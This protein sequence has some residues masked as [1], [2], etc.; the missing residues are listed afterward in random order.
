MTIEPEGP[1]F[2]TRVPRFITI[3]NASFDESDVA[4]SAIVLRGRV[5][6]SSF[7]FF[8][9]DKEYQRALEDR[10]DIFQALKAGHV[11]P[12]IDIGIRGQDYFCDGADVIIRSPCYIIDGWQRVGNAMRLL[13][14][15]PDTEIRIGALLHFGTN[16]AW[17]AARFTALNNNSKRVSPSLHLR[18]LREQN[19]S[20][21]TIYGLTNNER[22][23]PLIGRVC[24]EQSMRREHLLPAPQ[25]AKACLYL[26]RHVAPY[27]GVRVDAIAA[28]LETAARR[29]TLHR[30]RQNCLEFFQVIEQCFGITTIEYKRAATQLRGSF[31]L[32]LARMF[33]QHVNFWDAA[34]TQLH[35]DSAWRS[36]LSRFP[37]NDPYIRQLAGSGGPAMEILFDLLIKHMNS[38]KRTNPLVMRNGG[39]RG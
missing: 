10:A 39:V 4:P 28:G 22:N 38:G 29:V 25:L 9:V 11:V 17:E 8:K 36:K 7:R 15:V 12:D 19:P 18:N 5:A 20:V 23:S 3:E 37:I 34:G 33:S 2:D 6:S 30:F 31:L 27:N 21:L 13:D 24:W 32:N 1:Q 16:Q 35:V 26:H 14:L